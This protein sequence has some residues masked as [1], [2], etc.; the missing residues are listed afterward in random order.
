MYFSPF[1]GLCEVA[2][3]P[4]LQRTLLR[5]FL[6]P[7]RD[8]TPMALRELTPGG[9]A[10]AVQNTTFSIDALARNICN[11]WDEAVGS[12]GPPFTV[13]VV[14][15]GAY[16]GYLAAKAATL[17]PGA[18][19]LVLEAGP[20]LLSEHVQNLGDVGLNVASADRTGERPGGAARACV[21]APLARQ[22]GV[23]RSRVLLRREVA[24]LGRVVPPAHPRRSRRVACSDGRRPHPALR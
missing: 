1:A 18:R 4:F 6:L 15:S 23:S 3:A 21:G 19:V 14:G 17:H 10:A 20:F 22:R 16:G 13:I 2:T 7:I 24:V 12:G 5:G 8:R 11:T 9:A